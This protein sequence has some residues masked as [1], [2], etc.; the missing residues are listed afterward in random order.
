[1]ASASFTAVGKG[2]DIL[3]DSGSTIAY[4]LSGTFIGILQLVASSD[5]GRSWRILLQ[6]T[7]AVSGELVIDEPA[8]QRSL[9]CWRCTGYTSGTAVTTYTANDAIAPDERSVIDLVGDAADI[10]APQVLAFLSG[11]NNSYAQQAGVTGINDGSRDDAPLLAVAYAAAVAAGA[12]S[13]I[14]P[15]GKIYINSFPTVSTYAFSPSCVVEV[16]VSNFKIIIPEGCVIHCTAL[17]ISGSSNS[18]TIF[19]INSLTTNANSSIEGGGVFIHDTPGYTGATPNNF[20]NAALLC[21]NTDNC[22]I[23]NLSAYG[24]GALY[25]GVFDSSSSNR[26]QVSN[27][28]AENVGFGPRQS[29]A[30]STV[31]CQMYNLRVKDFYQDAVTWAANNVQVSNAFVQQ[32]VSAGGTSV[33]NS[34]GGEFCEVSNIKIIGKDGTYPAFG[35]V[36]QQGNASPTG[37]THLNGFDIQ[38]C[39]MGAL[40]L[41]A[42]NKPVLE[43]G[44]IRGSSYGVWKSKNG[45]IHCSDTVLNNVDISNVAYCLLATDKNNPATTDAVENLFNLSNVTMQ[46]NSGV[47]YN[48]SAVVGAQSNV[49]P[50]IGIANNALIQRVVATAA[51]TVTATAGI[52]G[53]SLLLV[54]AATLATLTVV[55]PTAPVDGQ[56]FR[57]RS[58]Q[59]VTTLTVT[60]TV[61]GSP[62][63]LTAGYDRTFIY[64]GTAATW[65]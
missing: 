46:A 1:M 2:I 24:F 54:P 59:I 18:S 42:R 20:V 56:Q 26:S 48:T 29:S 10:T 30:A 60:G 49:S 22:K 53:L 39:G 62:T 38:N 13:F 43:N 6:K 51:S 25:F 61:A 47:I 3:V 14:L 33:G 45:S 16:L 52:G 63:A 57:L 36:L 35:Y 23:D 27:L 40:L 19:Q 21:A 55:F 11:A 12:D 58:T 50:G 32:T 5:G 34:N 44:R 41:G 15:R 4:A 28:Y 65:L 9:V 17:G 31:R 7:A 8:N 37:T 64:D